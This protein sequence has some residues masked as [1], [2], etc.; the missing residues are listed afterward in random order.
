[1]SELFD[2]NS[3]EQWLADGAKDAGDAGAGGG[4]EGAGR[5]R[6]P[7]DRPR[8]GRGPGRVHRQARAGAAR[9]AGLNQLWVGGRWVLV[10]LVVV[11]IDDSV[12]GVFI[13]FGGGG[14]MS[15]TVHRANCRSAGSSARGQPVRHG[16]RPPDREPDGAGPRVRAD[17]SDLDAPGRQL[18]QSSSRASSWSTSC[19]TSRASTRCW[20]RASAR[21]PQAQSGAGLFT[22]E[23][24]DPN[25][26]KAHN[27]LLPAFSMDAMRGYHPMM[28]DIAVQLD[29]EV[30]AA[31][32][33]T[34]RSTCRPT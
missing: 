26:R 34:T 23:T 3:F 10:L 31:E 19:A 28:L 16:Q 33:R 11:A 7:A 25:W 21:W 20:G 1:M 18:A 14:Y 15:T 2:N 8:H 17:L 5:L 22:S 30:G 6:R 4:Q 29:A 32:R 9:Q 12:Y 24:S 27:I 13:F